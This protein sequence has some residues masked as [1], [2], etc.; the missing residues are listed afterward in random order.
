MSHDV[1]RHIGITIFHDVY[2]RRQKTSSTVFK[3]SFTLQRG[4]FSR[5][6]LARC[7]NSYVSYAFISAALR[8][9]KQRRGAL[10][11]RSDAE[12]AGTRARP[13]IS[14]GDTQRW[15]IAEAPQLFRQRMKQSGGALGVITM[16]GRN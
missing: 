12:G 16:C 15:G 13:H 5:H 6:P 3:K 2:S 14:L 4:V 9:T 7:G 10:G 8:K 1:F 11:G